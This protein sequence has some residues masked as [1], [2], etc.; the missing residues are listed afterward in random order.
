MT[1]ALIIAALL[2][3]ACE[4]KKVAH[5]EIAPQLARTYLCSQQHPCWPTE[6]WVA[7][8]SAGNAW[9][10]DRCTPLTVNPDRS[11]VWRCEP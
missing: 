5:V 4:G 2:L 9:V 3:S 1:R 6:P 8:G 11:T 10:L 7:S